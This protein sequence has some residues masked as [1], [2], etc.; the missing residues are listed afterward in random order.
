MVFLSH[1]LY[2]MPGLAPHMD[3]LFWEQLNFPISFSQGYV[4]ELL[5]S[6]FRKFYNRYGD[7]IKQYEVRLSQMLNDIL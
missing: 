7:L 2:V 6:S 5:K 4:K 3:V 1:S